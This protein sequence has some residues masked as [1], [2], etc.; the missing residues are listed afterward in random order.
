MRTEQTMTVSRPTEVANISAGL[1]SDWS[2]RVMGLWEQSRDSRPEGPRVRDEL[3]DACRIR[4]EL[5]NRLA[6]THPEG[7]L[8]AEKALEALSSADALFLQFTVES[9]TAESL[10][11]HN[12]YARRSQWWWRRHPR[13]WAA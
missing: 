4:D 13:L 12:H 5:N 8:C 1:I 9:S 3:G 10:S 11:Q 2:N 7:T 6:L